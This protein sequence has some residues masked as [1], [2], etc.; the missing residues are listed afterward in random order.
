MYPLSWG[1]GFLHF[2]QSPFVFSKEV[3]LNPICFI[4]IFIFRALS[5]SLTIPILLSEVWEGQG[6]ANL[7]FKKCNT[8]KKLVKIWDIFPKSPS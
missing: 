5:L 3:L 4:R 1:I 2:Y 6:W 8:F 7:F